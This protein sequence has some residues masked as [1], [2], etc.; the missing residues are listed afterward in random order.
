MSLQWIL[1]IMDAQAIWEL[2]LKVDSD[3]AE[4]MCSFHMSPTTQSGQNQEPHKPLNILLNLK[5]AGCYQ[6]L[7]RSAAHSWLSSQA[8]AFCLLLTSSIFHRGSKWVRS[9][10]SQA[11]RVH[12]H[13]LSHTGCSSSPP[14]PA[15]AFE[16]WLHHE[17]KGQKSTLPCPTH[18]L[19]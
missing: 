5:K 1:E 18:H 4:D 3:A 19:S 14:K 16:V 2:W 7:L 13:A 15:R 10:T 9:S 8:L 11:T 17:P 6:A 12:H